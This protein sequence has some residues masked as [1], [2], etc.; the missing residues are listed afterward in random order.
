MEGQEKS[1]GGNMMISKN[2]LAGDSVLPLIAVIVLS[3]AWAKEAKGISSIT[4]SFGEFFPIVS[5]KLTRVS[6]ALPADYRKCDV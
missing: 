3:T 2:W 1:E 6:A 4:K 5:G